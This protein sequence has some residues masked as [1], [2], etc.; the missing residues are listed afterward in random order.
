MISSVAK[1]ASAFGRTPFAGRS[2]RT[3]PLYGVMFHTTGSGVP[4]ATAKTPEATLAKALDIYTRS[5]GPHYVIGW[6][7]TTVATIADDQ[8]RGAHAGITD[9]TVRSAYLN[10]GWESRVS[11]QGVALWK[12]R[13]PGAK[14]PIDLIPNRNPSNI[15]DYWI[16]VEMIPVTSGGAA[17]YPPAYPGS[18]FSAAQHASA[19]RLA[20]EIAN[21]YGFPAGWKSP[22]QSRLVGHSD[23]NPVDRDTPGLPLWDPGYHTGM[24]N[25]DN[26]RGGDLGWLVAAGLAVAAGLWFSRYV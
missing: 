14:S 2:F 11:P 5:G 1:P 23:L 10:G 18:R 26:V 20:D 16:G 24:F 12:A 4:N 7:G 22:S 19:R 13:W 25:M 17:W 8:I 6:D 9:A 3:T 15:N 21:R